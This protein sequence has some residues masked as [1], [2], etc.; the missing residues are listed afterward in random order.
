MGKKQIKLLKEKFNNIIENIENLKPLIESIEN[1]D[2]NAM[3]NLGNIYLNG[4]GVELDKKKAYYYYRIAA[5]MGFKKIV[6]L[7]IMSF[8]CSFFLSKL[9]IFK[10]EDMIN[11]LKNTS[12]NK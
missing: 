11:L 10:S 7:C 9:D 3:L 8:L 5:Y 1:G 2:A 12:M 4:S 6:L